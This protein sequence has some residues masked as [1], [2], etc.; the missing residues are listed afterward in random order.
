LGFNAN[1]GVSVSSQARPKSLSLAITMVL[2][3]SG[4]ARPS[5]LS[6]PKIDQERGGAERGDLG[7]RD[8]GLSS[9]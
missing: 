2:P 8:L 4:V 1:G 5:I 6:R 9:R 7:D 3:P